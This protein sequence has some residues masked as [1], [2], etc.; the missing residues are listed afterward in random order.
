MSNARCVQSSMRQPRQLLILFGS[1]FATTVGLYIRWTVRLDV[2]TLH[3]Q[4]A[5]EIPLHTR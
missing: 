4:I 5:G 2:N 3:S 1:I